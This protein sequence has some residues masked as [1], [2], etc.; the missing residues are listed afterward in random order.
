M[1]HA[2]SLEK[3]VE[4][5][6]SGIAA[7]IG[8]PARARI[9]YCLMDGHART[10]TELAIVADVSPST[11]S[12]HLSRLKSQGLVAMLSRGKHHYYRLGGAEVA[13]AL[14]ALAVVAGGTRDEPVAD[15]P[16]RLRAA[17]TCYD[18]MAGRL[19]VSLHD[20]FHDLGWLSIEESHNNTYGLTE[21]GTRSLAALGI[22]I[23][24]ARALRRRF[25]CACIDWS[26]HRPHMG[27]ALG[28][29]FLEM[30]FRKQWVVRNPGSRSL[31]VTPDGQREMQARFGAGD[32]GS[33]GIIGTTQAW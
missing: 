30:A 2:I 8:E 14:E 16:C 17:R 7:A 10:S 15:A 22:E 26:E 18:H 31:S 6:V 13:A 11:A 33:P 9:L 1:N 4:I 21:A 29:A 19:A 20:R 27:G 32:T 28:A 25:A 5:T 12:M 23:E 24:A 3:S